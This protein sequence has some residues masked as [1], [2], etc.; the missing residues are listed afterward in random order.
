MDLEVTYFE[1]QNV[2]DESAVQLVVTKKNAQEVT[3]KTKRISLIAYSRSQFITL[4]LFKFMLENIF[5]VWSD[6]DMWSYI[7]KKVR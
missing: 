4:A 2:E 3:S 6:K 5:P 7:D 1:D